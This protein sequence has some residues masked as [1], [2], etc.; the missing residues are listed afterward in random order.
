VESSLA[1]QGHGRGL[2]LEAIRD[3]AALATGG[4]RPDLI[5]LLDVPVEVGLAR[6]YERGVHDRLEAEVRD[7]HERV[8]AGYE[9]L[10][11]AEPSRWLKLEGTA[12]ADAVF[13]ALWAGLVARGL[14]REASA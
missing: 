3:L 12:P 4:L 11:G 14:V 7:F 1:Y 9:S 10:R 5:V 13:E 8:R 2:P 6:V